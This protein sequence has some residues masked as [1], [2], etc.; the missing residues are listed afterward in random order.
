MEC[1][2]DMRIFL[3]SGE[4]PYGKLSLNL[5]QEIYFRFVSQLFCFRTSISKIIICPQTTNVYSFWIFQRFI[6]HTFSENEL[7]S[8]GLIYLLVSVSFKIYI[9]VHGHGPK[10]GH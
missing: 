6:R 3:S 1:D 2:S 10:F 5:K 4:F 9:F 8:V 7:C